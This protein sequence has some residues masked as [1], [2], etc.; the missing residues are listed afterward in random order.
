MFGLR[1]AKL[2]RKIWFKS[3]HFVNTITPFS[4]RVRGGNKLKEFPPQRTF[5]PRSTQ[6]WRWLCVFRNRTPVTLRRRCGFPWGTTGRRNPTKTTNG[7]KNTNFFCFNSRG[8]PNAIHTR[9]TMGA[10]SCQ[11]TGKLESWAKT[12][13]ESHCKHASWCSYMHSEK[14]ATTV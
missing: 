6:N 8:S 4:S 12:N 7:Q 2:W 14:E 10:E 3:F 5:P 1:V 13:K 9:W 11:G